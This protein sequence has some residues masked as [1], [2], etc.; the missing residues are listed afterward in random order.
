MK[1]ENST[2]Q[3]INWLV[4]AAGARYALCVDHGSVTVK[5]KKNRPTKDLLL[6]S[7]LLEYL[8]DVLDKTPL[9]KTYLL[10]LLLTQSENLSGQPHKGYRGGGGGIKYIEKLHI[11]M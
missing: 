3:L 6:Y 2:V 9:R 1:W 5:K 4:K 8:I 10:L 11:A 7:F